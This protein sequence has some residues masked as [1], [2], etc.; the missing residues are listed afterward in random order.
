MKEKELPYFIAGILMKELPDDK[1]NIA[2]CEII[3]NR[4]LE[5]LKTITLDNSK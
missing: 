2:Q 5:A 4:A 3:L 1:R